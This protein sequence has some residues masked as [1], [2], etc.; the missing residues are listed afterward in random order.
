MIK[1]KDGTEA[2]AVTWLRQPELAKK[3]PKR[4][5]IGVD[6]GGLFERI[7]GAELS[8]ERFIAAQQLKWG[9]MILSRS[10]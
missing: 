10:S 8:A 4:M 5:F 7:F 2:Y 6:E 1:I 3:N 9:L